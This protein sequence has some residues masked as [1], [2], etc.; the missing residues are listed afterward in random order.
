MTHTKGIWRVEEDNFGCKNI[1]SDVAEEGIF[2]LGYTHGLGNEDEDLANAHLIAAA[3]A[4]YE[5]LKGILLVAIPCENSKMEFEKT[6]LGVFK[7]LGNRLEEAVS[8]LA[9]AE[10]REKGVK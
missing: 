3:P 4:M 6:Y 5:A 9:K 7:V 2:S 8:A 10:S 1:V